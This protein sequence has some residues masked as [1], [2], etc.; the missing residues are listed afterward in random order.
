M[1][2]YRF[3]VVTGVIALAIPQGWAQTSPKRILLPNRTLKYL[4]VPPRVESLE[5]LVTKGEWYGRLR[6]NTFR[7]DWKE[8]VY[9]EKDGFNLG[10]KDNWAIGAGASLTLKTAYYYGLGATVDAYTSQ[11]PWHMDRSDA[12]IVKAG[13]DTFSRY[14]AVDENRWQMNVIAQLYAEY[15]L[16]KSSLKY[17]RQKFESLLTKSND[18]KMIPNTF[19]GVSLVS[20]DLPEHTF[21]LAWFTKQK[22]RD[23]TRFHDVIT[24]ADRSFTG[25]DTEE[26]L[27]AAWANNDDSGGHRGLSWQNFVA[28]GKSTDHDLLVAEVWSRRLPRLRAMVNYTAVPGVL[29]YATA[30]AHYAVG[31]GDFTLVPGVRYMRQLDNGGGAVGGAS[32]TGLIGP[33]GAASGQSGGYKDPNSLDGWLVC[34]RL[35]LK[36]SAPWKLRLGY[37]HVGDEADIVAPWRGFPTGG[38]TRIMGQYNWTAN[39]DTWMLRGDYDF[40]KAG[41]V[42][43]LTAMFRLGFEDYDDNKK[44]VIDGKEVALQRTDRNVLQLDA[45]Y[46]IPSVPGL[47]ARVRMA[48]VDARKRLDG[49]DPSYNEYRFEMNYLF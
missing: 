20:K 32:V 28:S 14:D 19:E 46:R 36:S 41:W 31:A 3:A 34:A 12:A 37:S 4:V 22:L 1:N 18:T 45:I 39:T 11:N 23:H 15:R 5:E 49:I 42:K 44:V 30:E 40:G 24:Y 25:L 2:F 13:K 16:R 48:F 9:R 21:K 47:Q 7:W 29:S 43:G 27:L 17:G 35:D 6:L 10:T 33:Y 8:P 38:F 26:K